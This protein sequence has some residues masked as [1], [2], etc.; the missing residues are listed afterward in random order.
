MLATFLL[1]DKVLSYGFLSLLLGNF[2]VYLKKKDSY[3][4]PLPQTTYQV[5]KIF[6]Y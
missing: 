4:Y 2:A 3:N 1:L 6:F 5:K